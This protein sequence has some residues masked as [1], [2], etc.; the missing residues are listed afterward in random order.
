MFNCDQF[1]LFTGIDENDEENGSET[2]EVIQCSY[3]I[4]N[5]LL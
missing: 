4:Q 5:I 1:N 3:V 2:L